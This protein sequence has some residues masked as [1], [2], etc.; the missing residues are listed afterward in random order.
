VI[1]V[2]SGF[3][4]NL[5][6]AA[7]VSSATPDPTPGNNTGGDTDTP[8][9]QA[10]L[11]ATKDDGS[12][13]FTAGTDVSYTITVNNSG[14]SDAQ[15]LLLS[16]ALPVGTTFV[17]LALPA[18]WTRTDATAVGANGTITATLP[19]LVAGAPAQVFTLVI[20]VSSGFSGNLANT[21]VISSAT[22][23]PIPGNNSG[24]D[25]DTPNPQAD[26]S[27]TKDDGSATYTAGTDVSY[28]ITVNNGGPSDA[29]ALLLS[30]ALPAGTT[31]VS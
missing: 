8:N 25:T 26:L 27:A 11:S 14:P 18:G 15:T 22:P 5:A 28:T 2:P 29:Q 30:D 21:A 6:N 9:P 12:G 10:D 16:D 17:S 1:H 13:T 23:D 31:F 4:G 24:T 20:H 19:T 7:T 3:S